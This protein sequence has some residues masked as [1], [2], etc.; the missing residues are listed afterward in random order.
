MPF[1][2]I[3]H[4]PATLSSIVREFHVYHANWNK[5]E[6]LPPPYITCLANTE[7]NLYFFP[8]DPIRLVIDEK[9]EIPVPVSAITGP[10]Y[11]PV[12]LLYGTN[13]L[14][15]KVAFH[16]TGTYRLLGIPMQQTV[17]A[18]L[19][20]TEFWG[21]DVRN[22]LH[23]LQKPISYDEMIATVID[24]LEKKFDSKCRPEEPID[25][26]AV[27]M[28]DPVKQFTLEKWASMACLSLRQFERNFITRVG[29]PPKLFLRIVRFEYAMRIKNESTYKSWSDVALEAGY[30]DSQHILKEFK[31]FADFPPSRFYLQPTPTSGSNDFPTG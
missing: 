14:M 28:L 3:Y 23:E 20:A 10:K 6:N 22:I 1:I 26:I 21:N 27:Q 31:E 4:P 2:K 29:I 16:P 11:K 25:T 7:Q 15:I 18:G 17:N 30:A 9:K 8:C 19:N 24:F 12:G 5:E 13:H